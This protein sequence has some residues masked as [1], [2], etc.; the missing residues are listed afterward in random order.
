[1]KAD[2]QRKN[3]DGGCTGKGWVSGQSGNPKGRPPKER[4]LRDILE[5]IGE[6]QEN[7]ISRI[8]RVCRKVWEEAGRGRRWAVEFIADRTEGKAASRL[9]IEA[10]KP[11]ANPEP[12]RIIFGDPK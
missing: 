2:K 6:E 8:E 12:T 1:M 11:R 9:E 10:A 4:C 7:G 3:N 5:A